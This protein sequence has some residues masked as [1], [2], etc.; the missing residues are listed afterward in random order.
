MGGG[1]QVKSE[2]LDY[3]VEK[4]YS[5]KSGDRPTQMESKLMVARGEGQEDRQSGQRE[6]EVQASSCRTS[7]SQG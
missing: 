6:R 1:G 2:V 5:Q 7:L 3:T 4:L